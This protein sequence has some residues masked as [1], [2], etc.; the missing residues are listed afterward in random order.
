MHRQTGVHLKGAINKSENA[1]EHTTPIFSCLR[2]SPETCH[3]AGSDASIINNERL[4]TI[5]L[6]PPMQTE[7]RPTP[8]QPEDL[9]QLQRVLELG[10]NSGGKCT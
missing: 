8:F 1:H 4:I 3:L 5:H 2:L 7:G 10:H 6:P 9:Q